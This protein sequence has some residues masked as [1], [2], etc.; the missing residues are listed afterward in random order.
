LSRR[1]VQYAFEAA[2]K[3]SGIRKKAT[4][5]SLRHAWATHLLEAGVSLRLIQIWLGHGSLST[6]AVY[7]HLTHH[8]EMLA[9]EAINRLMEEPS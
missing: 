8:A 6:T 2:L 5:H 7:T 4:V 9:I 1:S 3:E